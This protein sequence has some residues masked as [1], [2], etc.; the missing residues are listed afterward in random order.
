MMPPMPNPELCS[1]SAMKSSRSTV[2]GADPA[3]FEK[4]RALA[5][6]IEAA[7]GTMN[8]VPL[9]ESHRSVPEILAAVDLVFA[10]PARRG[11]DDRWHAGSPHSPPPER[12]R[13][14]RAVGTRSRETPDTDL[15][16][17]N[18]DAMPDETA[19]REL[20]RRIAA[21]ISGLIN[22]P[23]SQVTPGDIL[24]LVR[25]RDAFVEDMI[26]A[27]KQETPPIEV[28]GADRMNVMAQIAVKDLLAGAEFALNSDD[29]L[30]LACFLRSPL[31]G[32]ASMICLLSRMGGRAVCGER[33][34]TLLMLKM[35]RL[36]C[37]R[38]LA[39]RL[40]ARGGVLPPYDYFARFLSEQG[41]HAA[42]SARL[43]DEINGP[44][45]EL[46]NLA[47]AYESQQVP[48][49]KVFALAGAR[50]TKPQARYGCANPRRAGDDCARGQG[51]GSP[52]CVFA[53]YLH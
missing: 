47:L 42:L 35:L 19:R 38:A 16:I 12:R 2:S 18:A 44:I 15:Q 46:L 11:T 48:R 29:D 36:S 20:A 3:G 34:L 50:R 40:V 28:A 32:S 31:A 21:K 1:P 13:L 5:E 25:R 43:G 24:I 4:M 52:N 41:A 6:K 49:Y 14:C 22:A 51:A 30:A 8:F 26:R 17:G 39:A 9:I 23:D 53:G 33:W 7:G 45:G 27:L 37:A 10:E